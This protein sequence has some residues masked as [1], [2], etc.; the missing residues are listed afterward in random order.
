MA[1][2]RHSP[3]R[4]PPNMASIFALCRKDDWHSLLAEVNDNPMVAMTPMIMDNHISTTILHQA[5]TSKAN[6]GARA[7]VILAILEKAP[8]AASIKNGYGSLPL[9]VISQRNTK[10]DSQT[11]EHLIHQLVKINPDALVQEGGVGK[12]TPLHIA[13]T[14]YISPQLA[15]M[16]I[17]VGKA[18]TMKKDKKGWLPIHVA[19]SRH[20]SPEKLSMLLEANPNSLYATTNKG[21]SLLTLAKTNA[22][23]SHPN[24]RLIAE[25]EE[26]MGLD[27]NASKDNSMTTTTTPTTALQHE[28]QQYKTPPR[29]PR[30]TRKRKAEAANLLLHFSRHEKKISS[31]GA[32]RQHKYTPEEQNPVGNAATAAAVVRQ[33]PVLPKYFHAPRVSFYR[34]QQYHQQLPP[35]YLMKQQHQYVANRQPQYTAK[36]QQEYMAI[37][38]ARYGLKDQQEYTVMRQP[39]YAL[40]EQQEYR[41]N[42]H[43]PVHYA[44]QQILYSSSV[45][46]ETAQV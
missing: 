1:K 34:Q 18:A 6:T 20:C 41:T 35:P 26:R 15:S 13:F 32:V 38:Q 2:I 8:E 33:H 7:K 31:T 11:K 22:T 42:H 46:G 17:A 14:D 25:L 28:S 12:R 40:K 21:E 36:E 39:Q 37:R 30:L 44:S 4:K 43:P 9:H 23:K 27:T 19:V 45:V 3:S 10:M 16:M 5:I 24:Y 29:P